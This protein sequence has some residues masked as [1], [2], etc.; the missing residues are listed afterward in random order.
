MRPILQKPIVGMLALDTVVRAQDYLLFLAVDGAGD[1][2]ACQLLAHLVERHVGVQIFFGFLG[3]F[4]NVVAAIALLRKFLERH[5]NR[6]R[7]RVLAL[8]HQRE[9]L[10]LVV[11]VALEEAGARLAEHDVA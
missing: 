4:G 9:L 2:P 7:Q 11:G 5:P 8:T 10:R 1:A 6:L 3:P